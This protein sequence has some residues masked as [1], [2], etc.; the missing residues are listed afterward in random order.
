MGI[1]GTYGAILTMLTALKYLS[2]MI[3]A[4]SLL[5]QPI[6]A[7]IFATAFGL[8]GM[9]GILL[10][11]NNTV[12]RSNDYDRRSNRFSRII[13]SFPIRAC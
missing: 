5:I 4:L 10:N 13:R 6:I 9:P 11:N 12:Q 1:I 8:E 2:P 7:Q 3:I